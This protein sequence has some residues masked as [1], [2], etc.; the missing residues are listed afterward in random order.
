MRTER[1]IASLGSSTVLPGF[2]WKI[3]IQIGRQQKKA[4]TAQKTKVYALCKAPEIHRT[5]KERQK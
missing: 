1:E 2:I 5:K 4:Q 3:S